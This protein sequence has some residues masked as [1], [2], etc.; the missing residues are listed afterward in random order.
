M[1]SEHL[2]LNTCCFFLTERD[3]QDKV[4]ERLRGEAD[5]ICMVQYGKKGLYNV[6][7]IYVKTSNGTRLLFIVVNH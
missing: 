6:T 2:H 3:G 7:S 1:L 5:C 4:S